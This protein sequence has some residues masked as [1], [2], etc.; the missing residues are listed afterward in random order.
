M[1]P[2]DFSENKIQEYLRTGQI[3]TFTVPQLKHSK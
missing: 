2:N 1:K 3:T